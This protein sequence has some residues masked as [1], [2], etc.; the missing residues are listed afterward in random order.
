MEDKLKEILNEILNVYN[1]ELDNDKK[2]EM[3]SELWTFYYELS[4]ISGIKLDNAY[5]LYLI[6]EN[7]SYIYD[8]KPVR[9]N[10][11]IVDLKDALSKLKSSLEEDDVYMLESE[12]KIILDFIVEFTRKSFEQL[13]IS[14][15]KNS[16]NGFCEIGQ[17]LSTMPLENFGVE[18]TKNNAKDCFNYPF[19][20][21]FATATFKV[22]RN[23]KKEKVTYLIDTTYRQFFTTNRCNEGRYYT[24]EENTFVKTAPDPGYFIKDYSIIT[25]LLESGY[26]ELTDDVSYTYGDSFYKAGLTL[27]KKD[28]VSDIDYVNA[29]K[30]T[31]DYSVNYTD[32]D[33]FDLYILDN[34]LESKKNYL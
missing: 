21:V 27:D 11:E 17:A 30:K 6:G 24:E 20:H 14:V 15:N 13:G 8:V 7:E 4:D 16:L 1:R 19:N 31:S 2:H 26:I 10:I 32:L 33:G 22:M 18:V 23:N 25:D 28:L 34:I 5:N 3:L 29:F 9:K 12:V